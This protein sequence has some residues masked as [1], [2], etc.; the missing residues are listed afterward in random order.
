MT[1]QNTRRIKTATLIVM[2]C[3]PVAMAYEWIDSGVVSGVGVAIGVALA[4]PLIVLEESGFDRRLRRLPFSTALIA[5]ALTLIGSV[6]GVFMAT[7]LVQGYLTGLTMSDFW[8]ATLSPSFFQ[9]LAA[10]F[11]LYLVI[12]FFRQLDRLLGPGVLLRYVLG[13]YH[14]PRREARIFMFLDL[15]APPRP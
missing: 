8:E 3:V 9:E 7:S 11:V 2:V 13:R 12:V 5:K 1:R 10:G 14:R 6:A 15:K 4:M